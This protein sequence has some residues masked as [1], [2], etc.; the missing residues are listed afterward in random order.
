MGDA[1]RGMA[2][3]PIHRTSPNTPSAL[4]RAPETGQTVRASP[5]PPVPS[6]VGN[7]PPLGGRPG[8]QSLP[9]HTHAA[10]ADAVRATLVER[11]KRAHAPNEQRLDECELVPPLFLDLIAR[12]TDVREDER[13]PAVSAAKVA[14]LQE[15]A[16]FELRDRYLQCMQML[17]DAEQP[18][19]PISATSHVPALF[20]SERPAAWRSNF[21]AAKASLEA[22]WMCSHPIVVQL[23]ELLHKKCGPLSFIHALEHGAFPIDEDL[24]HQIQHAQIRYTGEVLQRDVMAEAR[25]IFDAWPGKLWVRPDQFEHLMLSVRRVMSRHLERLLFKALDDVVELFRRFEAN[26]DDSAL[27][28]LHLIVDENGVIRYNPQPQETLDRIVGL[29]DVVKKTICGF[30]VLPSDRMSLPCY[31]TMKIVSSFEADVMFE[32]AKSR[33]AYIYKHHA[34]GHEDLLARFQEYHFVLTEPY[35]VFPKDWHLGDKWKRL[36]PHWERVWAR[37]R[38]LMDEI[39]V[40]A[41]DEE[42]VGMFLAI[43]SGPDSERLVTEV[44]VGKA[45]SLGEHI[46][47]TI[48]HHIILCATELR[49]EFEEAYFYCITKPEESEKLMQIFDG[50]KEVKEKLTRSRLK[51]QHTEDL[52]KVLSNH[53]YFFED[54]DAVTLFRCHYLGQILPRLEADQKKFI[55]ETRWVAENDLNTARV[56]MS[57][58]LL[59]FQSTR[60]AA[61]HDFS[62]PRLSDEYLRKIIE[63]E[64]ELKQVEERCLELMDKQ[65]NFGVQ[66]GSFD[67]LENIASDLSR[68]KRLWE[69]CGKLPRM[70][71]SLKRHLVVELNVDRIKI[72]SE[73]WAKDIQLAINSFDPKWKCSQ[74][75]SDLEQQLS[76]VLDTIP[77]LQI[78]TH[79]HIRDRHWPILFQILDLDVYDQP[80]QVLYGAIFDLKTPSNLIISQLKSLKSTIDSEHAQESTISGMELRW[81]SFSIPIRALGA[82]YI[83]Y[84]ESLQEAFELVHEDSIRIEKLNVKN[85]T[86]EFAKEAKRWSE[87]VLFAENLLSTW[88]RVQKTFLCFRPFFASKHAILLSER[89]EILCLGIESS[90]KQIMQGAFEQPSLFGLSERLEMLSNLHMIE[91]D[92]DLLRKNIDEFVANKRRAFARFHFVVE[93]DILDVLSIGRGEATKSREINRHLTKIFPGAASCEFSE[94]SCGRVCGLRSRQGEILHFVPSVAISTDCASNSHELKRDIG[95]EAV[96]HSPDRTMSEV[97][98]TLIPVELWLADME[99]VMVQ[100]VLRQIDNARK[101]FEFHDWSDWLHH[102]TQQSISV[103]KSILCTANV[104][105]ILSGSSRHRKLLADCISKTICDVDRMVRAFGLHGTE[106]FR[107]KTSSLILQQ[108]AE[109]DMLQELLSKDPRGSHDFAWQS[110]LRYSWDLNKSSLQGR[111]LIHVM[112]QQFAYGLEYQGNELPLVWSASLQTCCTMVSSA[113]GSQSWSALAG[114]LSTSTLFVTNLSR[115]FGT[116]CIFVSC[117]IDPNAS[118]MHRVCKGIASSCFWLSLRAADQA[119]ARFLQQLSES[120]ISLQNALRMQ[121]EE[122]IIDGDLIQVGMMTG[123]FGDQAPTAVFLT[124]SEPLCRLKL[125]DSLASAFRPT[126]IPTPDMSHII[127]ITLLAHGFL[128]AG[129]LARKALFTFQMLREQLPSS[130]HYDFSNSAL[131]KVIYDAIDIK[132]QRSHLAEMKILVQSLSLK[133]SSFAPH[134]LAIF[135]DSICTISGED[136]LPQTI[137]GLSGKFSMFESDLS[138]FESNITLCSNSPACWQE[139]TMQLFSAS[140]ARSGVIAVGQPCTGKTTCIRAMVD[141]LAKTLAKTVDS[142]GVDANFIF[143][144]ALSQEE[145]YGRAGRVTSDSADWIYGLIPEL[146]RSQANLHPGLK[147]KP[148]I[149]FF[150]MDGP[151]DPGWSD[152]LETVVADE[153]YLE[154]PNFYKIP[155]SF[156]DTFVFEGHDLSTASPSLVSKCSIVFFHK[157]RLAWQQ[158]AAVQVSRWDPKILN[159]TVKLNDDSFAS[160]KDVFDVLLESVMAPTLQFVASECSEQ[161]PLVCE[162]HRVW[163][164][165]ILYERL[166]TEVLCLQELARAREQEPENEKVFTHC[167]WL[168]NNFMFALVWSFGSVL[169]PSSQ[170]KF[171]AFVRNLVQ[172]MCIPIRAKK[173]NGRQSHADFRLSGFQRSES[174]FDCAYTHTPIRKGWVP[175][176]EMNDAKGR[177]HGNIGGKRLEDFIIVTKNYI[178]YSCLLTWMFNATCPV[179]MH[180]PAACGKSLYIQENMQCFQNQEEVAPMTYNMSTTATSDSLRHLMCQRLEVRGHE[181]YGPKGKVRLVIC[182]EDLNLASRNAWHGEGLILE[183][184]RHLLNKQRGYFTTTIPPKL[185]KIQNTSFV[186]TSQQVG[187]VRPISPRL[188]R[189]MFVLNVISTEDDEEIRTIFDATLDWYQS[190]QMFPDCVVALRN[191]VVNATVAIYR[192]ICAKLKPSLL[193]PHY[194]FSLRDLNAVLSG[195]MLQTKE[196][197]ELSDG[198]PQNV[199]LRLWTHEILRVFYDRVKDA[200]DKSWFLQMIKNVVR[201]HLHQNFSV[202]F[203]HLDR[204]GDGDI[205]ANELRRLFFGDWLSGQGIS[206]PQREESGYHEIDRP[207]DAISAMTRICEQYDSE[208]AQPMNLFM[209]LYCVEHISRLA[210]VLRMRRGHSL[211]LGSPGVGRRSLTRMAAYVGGAKINELFSSASD[212]SHALL[213]RENLKRLIRQCGLKLTSKLAV[214]LRCCVLDAERMQDVC[215]I[216][217]GQE[218]PGLHS[219]AER[220][221]LVQEMQERGLLQDIALESSIDDKYSLLLEVAYDALHLVICVDPSSQ[222]LRD[223]LTNFPSLASRCH[224]DWFENWP[225]DTMLQMAQE[226]LSAL[227]RE[228]VFDS[229]HTSDKVNSFCRVIIEK[230]GEI[231]DVGVAASKGYLSLTNRRNL[232]ISM[233][234]YVIFLRQFTTILRSKREELKAEA[235]I[236]TSACNIADFAQHRAEHEKEIGK[237]MLDE[238]LELDGQKTKEAAHL[239]S[240]SSVVS[241]LKSKIEALSQAL[242]QAQKTEMTT[243]DEIQ[244]EEIAIVQ[245][246]KSSSHDVSTITSRDLGKLKSAVNLEQKC[247]ECVED[248]VMA[249]YAILN[250]HL[251]PCQT[252]D[253]RRAV[254]AECRKLISAPDLKMKMSAILPEPASS[255]PLVLGARIVRRLF[256]IKKGF[257]R[258][259]ISRVC[260][261]AE[262]VYDWVMA[263]LDFEKR[264]GAV[265]GSLRETLQKVKESLASMEE[266]RSSLFQEHVRISAMLVDQQNVVQEL[267]SKASSLDNEYAGLNHQT[268]LYK[269]LYNNLR[270]PLVDFPRDWAIRLEKV[271]H[272]QKSLEIDCLLCAA[273]I[274][275]LG[276]L[277]LKV[278]Q[279]IIRAWI[280]TL[281]SEKLCEDENLFHLTEFLI[282][283]KELGLERR[284]LEYQGLPMDQSSIMNACIVTHCYKSPLVIDPHGVF[285][286]WIRKRERDNSLMVVSINEDYLGKLRFAVQEGIPT[287]VTDVDHALPFAIQR[288]SA[289]Q[290]VD[291]KGRKNVFIGDVMVPCHQRFRLYMVTRDECP[292]FSTEEVLWSTVVDFNL[293]QEGF[294]QCIFNGL[295]AEKLEQVHVSRSIG[296]E[297]YLASA[298]DLQKL[299]LRHYLPTLTDDLVI[300]DGIIE[301]TA[302][303]RDR[304]IKARETAMDNLRRYNA[305]SKRVA[306]IDKLVSPLSCLLQALWQITPLH[307]SY[308]TVQN[309]FL[310]LTLMDLDSAAGKEGTDS[311]VLRENPS[312]FDD[313]CAGFAYDDELHQHNVDASELSVELE[314]MGNALAQ[315]VFVDLI[316]S[317]YEKDHLL[318][319]FLVVVK[320]QTDKSLIDPEEYQHFLTN[321]GSEAPENDGGVFIDIGDIEK[322]GVKL[323]GSGVRGSPTKPHPGFQWLS[324]AQWQCV[325]RLSSLKTIEAAFGVDG[326]I[327]SIE[328]HPEVWQQY[329]AS[330]DPLQ[331]HLPTTLSVRL[332]SFQELLLLRIFHP[333]CVLK[334]MARVVSDWRGVDVSKMIPNQIATAYEDSLSTIPLLFLLGAG[335]DPTEDI[336]NFAAGGFE[337]QDS[338]QVVTVE[339]SGFLVAGLETSLEACM[340]CGRW[341]LVRNAHIKVDLGQR[342]ERAIVAIG[343]GDPHD[344]F[345]L[346]ITSMPENLS[347]FVYRSTMRVVWDAPKSFRA[348]LLRSCSS[349]PLIADGFSC[350]DWEEGENQFLMQCLF[351]LCLFHAAVLE[352]CLY[353]AVGWNFPPRFTDA[354]LKFCMLRVRSVLNS[355]QGF[356]VKDVRQLVRDLVYRGKFDDSHDIETFKATLVT[357]FPEENLV[358]RIGGESFSNS[359]FDDLTKFQSYAAGLPMSAASSMFGLDE[360]CDVERF[361]QVVDTHLRKLQDVNFFRPVEVLEDNSRSQQKL[362]KLLMLES[363]RTQVDSLLASVPQAFDLESVM[364]K[365]PVSNQESRNRLLMLEL[366]ARN[367]LLESIRA[368]LTSLRQSLNGTCPVTREQEQI[369]LSLYYEQV[370]QCWM[371][372]SCL[373]RRPLGAYMEL[374]NS[375]SNFFRDWLS[376][377]L[378]QRLW[379]PAFFFPN[380]LFRSASMN[381]AQH[382][383]VGIEFVSLSFTIMDQHQVSVSAIDGIFLTG[384]S[385]YGA[386]WNFSTSALEPLDQ[387]GVAYWKVPILHVQPIR[388]D[389][390]SIAHSPVSI[391]RTIEQCSPTGSSSSRLSSSRSKRQDITCCD[392]DDRGR[393]IYRCP[394]YRT[395]VRNNTDC[396][397]ALANAAN[398]FIADIPLPCHVASNDATDPETFYVKRGTAFVI[399]P[400]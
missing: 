83:Y 334:G 38:N 222:N 279:S 250:G 217:N 74:I 128:Q 365:F 277:P 119:P 96:T 145:L 295:A 34:Q 347:K 234:D 77:V 16:F 185:S 100:S 186:A 23:N 266:E 109:R 70:T 379:L 310:T 350:L 95:R 327:G 151:M 338:R 212:S 393:N 247:P 26:D 183:L 259:F 132:K 206:S 215:L 252:G 141:A 287:L 380:A 126:S 251:N 368:T 199:H 384:V 344:D 68:H 300:D 309:S 278:R 43:T 40:L 288:L 357:F 8:V 352:R 354:D 159:Q 207:D 320:I 208:K 268:I 122:V 203:N 298:S 210:R 7:L 71:K 135:H 118:V 14:E 99:T 89:E 318:F 316:R 65:S 314:E 219:S 196:D 343:S 240:L 390:S 161:Y 85:A 98:E 389:P 39:E 112:E 125:P 41:Q 175:W 274:T 260:S 86:P 188:L 90:W 342:L 69:I 339:A 181:T 168:T 30:D 378:P 296:L 50:H 289:Q 154:L 157:S 364:A 78:W 56:R 107:H 226:H 244:E 273:S 158:S 174:V 376:T 224:M 193:C 1:R 313:I 6:R 134:D 246:W 299:D 37:S 304:W 79:P 148:K 153:K 211:L 239:E 19:T 218:I 191:Q 297:R 62:S 21:A 363:T 124:L 115:S 155:S 214:L 331:M 150:V 245:I 42:D 52:A 63:I 362:H 180:G 333:H 149:Q 49:V 237:K 242:N 25:A 302:R 3:P 254:M 198:S 60:L 31:K 328:S 221:C 101:G 348:G 12:A 236:L 117:E 396:A 353:G 265:L 399:D 64:S 345:R 120:I 194:V 225:A 104:E 231:H 165:L 20:G 143:P 35:Y 129:I 382:S 349:T 105:E 47:G 18:A 176:T 131:L 130:L 397:T 301:T 55:N 291:K 204:D 190:Q 311:D 140:Q 290:F 398:G 88:S 315:M 173:R 256:S 325:C 102:H 286:S 281:A 59:E 116:A 10:G 280:R 223:L 136:D 178:R 358:E 323:E 356:T 67:A 144:A 220:Q 330:Q 171:D 272:M 241:D 80:S 372:Y 305:A 17:Q 370:P 276:G 66:A 170:R 306:I 269:I 2:L 253:E 172:D 232:H 5:S 76:H 205:D 228:S 303:I 53:S 209:S 36:V 360:S 22:K 335:T 216:L 169:E 75:A 137:Q 167:E 152:R 166:C 307:Q 54:D 312:I 322:A 238:K 387:K 33:L 127:E 87:K 230:C 374:L 261:G 341:L 271:T 29:L 114:R 201:D 308:Q 110:Q 91:H 24:F 264:E 388:I 195:M 355:F 156:L 147:F 257:N 292:N 61:L 317:I 48:A 329:L 258:D 57:S 263:A 392:G 229:V 73:A 113:L 400:D 27:F 326:V 391:T 324:D 162:V 82:S 164:L 332:N 138:N 108:M 58:L 111:V 184:I 213:W 381:F 123:S 282:D 15:E 94:R 202:L 284:H 375:G 367:T 255:D 385:L 248:L 285:T 351:S 294:H 383:L 227:F 340:E 142:G 337:Q 395:S 51:W 243:Q 121:A 97:E 369:V 133:A 46:K 72:S 187:I 103:A 45:K 81:K 92:L 182:L 366:D 249:V 319:A 93:E 179:L 283:S 160:G 163:S 235:A 321:S 361:K 189:H 262:K 13:P 146:L 377:G 336:Q 270:D 11:S 139:K 106:L 359:H 32:E 275:Y 200:E 386:C 9:H 267:T 293:T 233:F 44:L 84:V 197:L 346:W 192:E 28:I 177:S 4:Q 394:M 373:S 371:K